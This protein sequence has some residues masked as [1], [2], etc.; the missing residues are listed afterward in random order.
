[1]IA[2]ALTAG[3]I[4]PD[5]GNGT[6]PASP[7]GAATLATSKIDA[8][9]HVLPKPYLQRVR[10][11]ATGPYARLFDQY[12]SLVALHDL[13]HR[14]KVMDEF[15]DYVQVLTLVQPEVEAFGDAAVAADLAR[16]ANDGMA[17]LC[18][19]HPDRFVGFA[20]AVALSDVDG[21]IEETERA[22]GTLGALGVQIHTNIRG[23]PLDE[24]RF[25]PF[26]AKVAELGRTVWV[27]PVRGAQM[28]DYPS[29]QASRYG[30]WMAFGWPYETTVFMCRMVLS[31]IFQRHPDLRILTHH[32]GGMIPH[33]GERLGKALDLTQ[34]MGLDLGG[35][36]DPGAQH[37]LL[38]DQLKRFYGDT[39]LSGT[40]HAVE[41][42][43]GFFGVERLL[44]GTDMPFDRD[45]G[46]GYVRGA[47]RALD[48]MDL[49]DT[50]RAL[51]YAGN[52]RRVLGL[53]A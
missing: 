51:I 25:E 43:L 2:L 27:H 13:E 48:A 17:E 24:P 37:A 5:R 47:V 33:F 14:F 15:G 45:G 34:P 31:G 21:A 16:C 7:E 22:V 30:M 1:V 32:A 4:R 26:F 49:A 11:L 19:V 38:L 50:D 12:E 20:A 42:G 39:S 10:P 29:E 28:A 3:G 46:P 9:P 36:T 41:C 23:V 52:A 6:P 44:F 53:P 8:F 18:R 40:R 35:A